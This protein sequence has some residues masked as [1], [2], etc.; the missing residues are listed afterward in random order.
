MKRLRRLIINLAAV[1]G[2][3]VASGA[4]ASVAMAATTT[5]TSSTTITPQVGQPDP[6]GQ[7]GSG[8]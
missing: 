5:T 1:A 2:L 3:L 6:I 7:T 4:V 8:G